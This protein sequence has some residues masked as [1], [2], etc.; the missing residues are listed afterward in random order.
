VSELLE[1][2][3]VFGGDPQDLTV[4]LSGTLDARGLWELNQALMAD[5]RLTPGMRILVDLGDVDASPLDDDE[6]FVGVGPVHERD[7]M[8]PPRAVAIIASDPA[9]FDR[10]VHYRAHLGGS[11]SRRRVFASR[12]DGLAWLAAQ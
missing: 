9:T 11:A 10:A 4:T 8:A 6:L 1:F 12:A 3:F 2:V 5:P 7:S